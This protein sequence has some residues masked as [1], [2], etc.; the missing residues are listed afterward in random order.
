MHVGPCCLVLAVLCACWPAYC[1]MLAVLC[2]CWPMLLSAGLATCCYVL[3]GNV[4]FSANRAGYRFKVSWP[5]WSLML[6]TTTS[7]YYIIMWPLILVIVRIDC[8]PWP[9][10]VTL[11]VS[12]VAEL[13]PT[14]KV[15]PQKWMICDPRKSSKCG[16]FVNNI[17]YHPNVDDIYLLLPI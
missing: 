7:S 14:G 5:L 3:V 4:A 1:L 8:L 2:A 13:W 10:L 16:W 11:G 12:C 6:C 9:E 15:R 17:I